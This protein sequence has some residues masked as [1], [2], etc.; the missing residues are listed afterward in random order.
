MAATSL[1]IDFFHQIYTGK[2]AW[3]IDATQPAIVQLAEAGKIIGNVLDIGC[4]TGC[5]AIYLAERG[6]PVVAFDLVPQAIEQAKARLGHRDL[7]VTFQVA[8]VLK[9]PD[10]GL[11]DTAIDAGVFHVFND[12]DR[13]RYTENIRRHLKPGAKLYLICFSE[14]QPG[15]E[16]PRRVTQ[17]EIRDSFRNGWVVESIEP[18][19]YLTQASA[20]GPAKAWLATIGA[21]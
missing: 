13:P 4:G 5:N 15:T 18:T 19:A 9:L 20:Y 11:F 8:N 16:G 1:S 10:L 17:Q 12:K 2:P 21:K 14:H 6:H 7:P 3:E